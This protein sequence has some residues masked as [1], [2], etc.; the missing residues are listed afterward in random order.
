MQWSANLPE[1]DGF[2]V[3]MGRM[4]RSHLSLCVCERER[5]FVIP[6]RPE[7]PILFIC[8]RNEGGDTAW[9]SLLLSV[10][11]KYWARHRRTYICVMQFKRNYC[12]VSHTALLGQLDPA[13]S[14]VKED[15]ACIAHFYIAG[16]AET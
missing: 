7:E 2:W 10:P 3:F 14:S 9:P 11:F 8:F 13:L 1:L 15:R 6:G 16:K 5:D 4:V 12:S